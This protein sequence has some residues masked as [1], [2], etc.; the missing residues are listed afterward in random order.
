M[1]PVILVVIVVVTDEYLVSHATAQLYITEAEWGRMVVLFKEVLTKHSI[2]E[3]EA[4][5]L[6]D[7][8]GST[9]ADI[10]VAA[11]GE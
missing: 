6:L 2:P 8:I 3:K 11:S 9:K 5:E 7:I 1:F 10:V 4:Q